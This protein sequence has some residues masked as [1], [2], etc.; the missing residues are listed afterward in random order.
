MKY[1]VMKI[2]TLIIIL[3]LVLSVIG[4]SNEAFCQTIVK[5]VPII[6]DDAYIIKVRAYNEET[7][8]WGWYDIRETGLEANNGWYFE[9]EI[10]IKIDRY[11]IAR[12]M[13]IRGYDTEDGGC[14]DIT[15]LT[16]HGSYLKEV[17]KDRPDLRVVFKVDGGSYELGTKIEQPNG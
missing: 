8:K 13:F 2:K 17:V 9:Q 5:N 12:F 3:T 10:N 7:T 15:H 6:C 14:K 4:A 16:I 11:D 1:E